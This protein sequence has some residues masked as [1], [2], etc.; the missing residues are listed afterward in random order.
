M[1]MRQVYNAICASSAFGVACKPEYAFESERDAVEEL[2]ASLD[3]QKLFYRDT[4]NWLQM[5]YSQ[6][7]KSWILI[8]IFL[9]SISVLLLFALFAL[10]CAEKVLS[11][12]SRLYHSLRLTQHR[13]G[14]LFGTRIHLEDSEV[15]LQHLDPTCIYRRFCRKPKPSMRISRKLNKARLCKS[16]SRRSSVHESSATNLLTS[17]VTPFDNLFSSS[18]SKHCAE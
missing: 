8:L 1:T 5:E 18:L 3:S 7:L 17:S 15:G 2:R 16:S 11:C 6:S 14:T 13:S 4:L 10:L 12:K 9:V